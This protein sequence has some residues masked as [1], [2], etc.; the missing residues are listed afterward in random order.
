[1]T[2]YQKLVIASSLGLSILLIGGALLLAGHRRSSNGVVV[3]QP[4][5]PVAKVELARA[6]GKNG[7]QCYVAVSGTV[8]MIDLNSPNWRNGDHTPSRGLAYCGAD[9]TKVIDQAP[10]G[11]QILDTLQ[12]VGP[13]VN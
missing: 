10:H 5:H 11:R 8:Y 12:K 13:L 9:L 3:T 4:Q 1:M 7:H 2:K 6:N